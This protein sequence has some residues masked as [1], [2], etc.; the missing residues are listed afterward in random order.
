MND[1]SPYLQTA[2]ELAMSYGPRLVLAIVTLFVG[3]A[4]INRGVAL[5]GRGMAAREVEHTLARFL[6]SVASV[7]LKVL[8][9]I[10]VASM[11]GI[12][13]TS[14][15]AVLGAAGLAVGFALQGS[16]ANFAG[17]VLILL[18]RPFRAGDAIDAQG[19]VGIVSEIQIFNT[20]VK[21]F[22]NKV[23][24]IPNGQLSNGVITNISHEPTRR[25]DM[26]F[27]IGYGDDLLKA[28]DTLQRIVTQDS[29][30]L[31]DPP[32]VV[33]VS[34]LGDSSVNFVVRTWVKA[35]DY[36]GV[37]F[38]MQE[39]VKLTFDSEGISIPFP[40]TDVHLHQVAA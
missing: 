16:L 36:W 11:I 30:V 29:R 40:Q 35:E 2:V 34:E 38:D 33:A 9:L 23:V 7:S 8:L 20:I 3:L 13:T 15:I 31:T 32:P 10:S 28:K 17:G 24:I 14:F 19:I 26:A 6:S 37:F 39:R 21:T 22:D 1:L 27:G 12:A 5:A 25:V 4:I 18:F